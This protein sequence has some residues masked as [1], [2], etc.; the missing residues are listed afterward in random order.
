VNIEEINTHPRPYKINLNEAERLGE[1]LLKAIE[2]ME[3]AANQTKDM[4]TFQI[5][6][7]GYNKIKD[8][9]QD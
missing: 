8:S 1:A 9:L 3:T 5:L 6:E 4:D 7:K 2:T